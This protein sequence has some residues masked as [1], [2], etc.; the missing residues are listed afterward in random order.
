MSIQNRGL[1]CAKNRM[2]TKEATQPA[3]QIIGHIKENCVSRD[4]VLFDTR[5]LLST[6]EYHSVRLVGEASLRGLAHSVGLNGNVYKQQAGGSF[7]S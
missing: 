2:R 5:V 4:V 1:K 7:Y 3:N 6:F